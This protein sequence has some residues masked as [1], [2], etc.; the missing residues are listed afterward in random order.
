MPGLSKEDRTELRREVGNRAVH[1]PTLPDRGPECL[2]PHACFSCRK[3]WKLAEASSAKCPEC[4]DELHWMGRAFKVPRKADKEQWSKV[5][6]L[7]RAG[8]R[9][10]NHSRW[11]EAEPYPDRFRDVEDFVRNNPQHPFRVEA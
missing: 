1:R 6:A 4:G 10:I 11:R 5:E 3:S 2:W 7:W 9:F 8:Y